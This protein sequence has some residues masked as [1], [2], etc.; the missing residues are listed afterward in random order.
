MLSLC[1]IKL[2][3]S[4]CLIRHSDTASLE[5]PA[6]VTFSVS[7][8]LWLLWVM[9]FMHCL[10][11]D[12]FSCY[13]LL[14][15]LVLL[16]WIPVVGH[17]LLLCQCFFLAHIFLSC[18]T[19]VRTVCFFISLWLYLTIHSGGGGHHCHHHYYYCCYIYKVLS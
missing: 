8:Q 17:N 1:L 16:L 18:F 11:Y 7:V 3:Q 10:V 2:Y 12:H 5:H 14:P 4:D 15:N 9:T 13:F 6:S 19:F